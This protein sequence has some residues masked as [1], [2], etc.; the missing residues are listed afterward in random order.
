ML[1]GVLCLLLIS[2]AGAYATFRVAVVQSQQAVLQQ[3]FENL[4]A[5]Y[6]R[7]ETVSAQRTEA[8]TTLASLANEVSA[9]YGIQRPGNS[10]DAA[11]DADDSQSPDAKETI[12]RFN[13]LKFA[14]Y[15]RA[16]HR[17]AYA[18]QSHSQPSAW[19]VMGALRSSFGGRVDPFSGDGAFH[20]GIDLQASTGTPVHVTADGVIASVGYRGRY[21]N[22]VVVDHGNGF[23]TYYA[24]LSQ[25]TVVPGQDVRI[26]Q[27][28]ALSGGTGRVTSPHLHY[29]VRIKGVPVNPYRF[30]K[31]NSEVAADLGT[32]PKANLGF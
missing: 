25:A 31:S 21:G 18:W 6:H 26:G 5:Q 29:E 28:I 32:S 22:L 16:Y 12:E 27:V 9:E 23:Q 7:L 17:Y 3:K 10:D 24:H 1:A 8:V 11:L 4:Q 13:F 2:G 30:L 15:A 14:S 20:T 19:P